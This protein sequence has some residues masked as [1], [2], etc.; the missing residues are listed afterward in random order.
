M[1]KGPDFGKT[2]TTGAKDNKKALRTLL[3]Y[4]RDIY[5]ADY[6]GTDCGGGKRSVVGDRP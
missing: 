6:N 4:C 5:C 1:S 2:V 3:G